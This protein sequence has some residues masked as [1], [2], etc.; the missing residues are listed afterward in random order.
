MDDKRYTVIY[1]S[2]FIV[3]TAPE[4]FKINTALSNKIGRPY[5]YL[6]LRLFR[7]YGFIAVQ[8]VQ[9]N[10][11][12]MQ[13]IKDHIY[14]VSLVLCIVALGLFLVLTNPDSVGIGLLIVPVL[15][16]FFIA[17]CVAQIVFNGLRLLHT[18]P[19]KQ[20]IVAL[21]SAS[22]VTLIVILQST[23]GVSTPDVVLLCLIIGVVSLYIDKF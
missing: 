15:L 16:F 4:L 22:F 20:R 10:I 19:R 17:F 11:I 2:G 12:I 9:F 7:A 5:L 3:P 21:L 23:G 6:S 1:K 13:I 18:K 8:P 14:A